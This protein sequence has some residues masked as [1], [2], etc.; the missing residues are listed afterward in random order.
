MP[1][2]NQTSIRQQ[3]ID[4]YDT[5]LGIFPSAMD[6]ARELSLDKRAS[7]GQ[8]K[9]RGVPME[10]IMILDILGLLSKDAL[11]PAVK[12]WDT[13][14]SK[15]EQVIRNKLNKMLLIDSLQ[16]STA[17]TLLLV[18]EPT[19]RKLVMQILDEEGILKL[20]DSEVKL[21]DSEVS[22]ETEDLM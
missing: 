12:N 10:Y 7:V 18:V 6:M 8:W 14:L 11:I 19:V 13:Y 22:L 17:S 9:K 4:A 16:K 1:N 21:P 15:Y 20:P 3:R 5:V 2:P